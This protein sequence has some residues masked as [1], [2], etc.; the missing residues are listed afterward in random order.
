MIALQRSLLH[1]TCHPLKT[2]KE[3]GDIVIQV[4]YHDFSLRVMLKPTFLTK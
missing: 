3:V 4:I 1:I 2:K